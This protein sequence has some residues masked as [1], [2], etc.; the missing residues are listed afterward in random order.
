MIGEWWLQGEGHKS[1]SLHRFEYIVRK[2]D[3]QHCTVRT[4]ETD[5]YLFSVVSHVS[6]THMTQM[7]FPLILFVDTGR[8]LSPI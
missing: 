1:Q 5:C 7:S 2:I 8:N 6:D 3:S 4:S